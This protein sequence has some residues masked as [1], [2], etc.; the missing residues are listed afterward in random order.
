M[1][2]GHTLPILLKSILML[3]TSCF[4]V[5]EAE[6]ILAINAIIYS[7]RK[8]VGSRVER[9]PAK[10]EIRQNSSII[11]KFARTNQRLR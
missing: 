9:V 5:L 6:T 3:P 11:E 10:Q 2:H 8:K 7:G 1:E 4:C